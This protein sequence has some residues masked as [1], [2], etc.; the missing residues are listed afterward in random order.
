MR[1][2]KKKNE[3]KN[4]Q[5]CLEISKMI[6]ITIKKSL[7]FHDLLTNNKLSS[8]GCSFSESIFSIN[9]KCK[10]NKVTTAGCDTNTLYNLLT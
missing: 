6:N 8:S 7:N 1:E 9:E 2:V 3:Y 4:I 10:G 5:C